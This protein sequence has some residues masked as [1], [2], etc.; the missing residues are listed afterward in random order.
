MEASNKLIPFQG[1]EY[2]TAMTNHSFDPLIDTTSRSKDNFLLCHKY[3]HD[4]AGKFCPDKRTRRP[5][6]LL[7]EY[8]RHEQHKK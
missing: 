5:K 4:S 7:E 1:I 8:E 3:I 6:P 2:L